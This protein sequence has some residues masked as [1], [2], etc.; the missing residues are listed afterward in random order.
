MANYFGSLKVSIE[1]RVG[2]GLVRASIDVTSNGKNLERVL[3]R[4]PH[5]QG[6]PA[7][8]CWGGGEKSVPR[9]DAAS[10]TVTI[11]PWTGK[12]EVVLEF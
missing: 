1:S 8:R 11:E 3:L 10:E 9:Y 6:I 5:P 7:V 12:A 4:L 2:Q